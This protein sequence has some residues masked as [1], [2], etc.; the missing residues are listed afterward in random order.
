MKAS[1]YNGA[2]FQCEVWSQADSACHCNSH[3]KSVY[4]KVLRDSV[5]LGGLQNFK[6]EVSD[7]DL[8]LKHAGSSS[9]AF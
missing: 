6:L 8:H 9:V 4:W 7:V 2:V 1:W 5:L 3:R